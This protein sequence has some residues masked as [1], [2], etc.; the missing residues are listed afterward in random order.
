M[1]LGKPK[2]TESVSW[3]KSASKTVGMAYRDFFPIAL[4]GR[5][6]G[7]LKQW[8]VKESFSDFSVS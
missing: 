2:L 3:E 5:E 7:T 8:K 6:T 4:L 1:V